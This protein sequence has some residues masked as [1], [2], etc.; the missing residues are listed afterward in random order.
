MSKP[1][2]ITLF[3]FIFLLT[4]IILQ[5]QKAISLQFFFWDIE[6]SIFAIPIIIIISAAIGYLL[7]SINIFRRNRKKTDKSSEN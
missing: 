4:V 3:T 7:A 1:K 5:N 2:L 6:L